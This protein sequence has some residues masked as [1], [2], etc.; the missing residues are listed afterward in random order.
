MLCQLKHGC[1]QATYRSWVQLMVGTASN[2]F[3]NSN[4]LESFLQHFNL[5]NHTISHGSLFYCEISFEELVRQT[6]ST[7]GSIR[8]Y[9]G[10]WHTMVVY[11]KANI[12]SFPFWGMGGINAKHTKEKTN[13]HQIS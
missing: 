2:I 8:R 6:L 10:N 4:L 3:Q 9:S 12:K 1:D 13:A 5:C 7:E 11:C